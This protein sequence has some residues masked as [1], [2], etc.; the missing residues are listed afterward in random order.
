M[1]AAATVQDHC[2]GAASIRTHNRADLL[3]LDGEVSVLDDELS[4]CLLQV[5]ALLVDN[6]RQKLVL[7]TTLSDGEVDE[8]GLS[9]DLRRIMGV[10]ELGVQDELEVLIVLYILVTQLYIQ[11][12]PLHTFPIALSVSNEL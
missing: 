3:E 12:T 6:Q 7:Q 4:L 2:A 8:G 10:A 9:L 11:A 5:R 1:L